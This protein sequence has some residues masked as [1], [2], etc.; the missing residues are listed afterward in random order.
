MS[1]SRNVFGILYETLKITN[2][3]MC[4]TVPGHQQLKCRALNYM[5]INFWV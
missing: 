3:A 5:I 2:V 1:V 4:I